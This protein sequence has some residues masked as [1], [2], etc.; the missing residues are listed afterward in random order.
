MPSLIRVKKTFIRLLTSTVNASKH[1][2]CVS[3]NNQKCLIRPTL[4]NFHPKEYTQG[5]CYYPFTVNLDRCVGRFNTL[6]GL[7]NKECVSNETEDL[8]LCVFNMI[9]G[10]NESKIL[11][12][13]ISCKPECKFGSIKCNSNQNYDNDKCE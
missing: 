2:K 9:T 10:T 12:K 4:I 8:N 7:S 5:F 11:V 6:N 3:L 1:T 13:H